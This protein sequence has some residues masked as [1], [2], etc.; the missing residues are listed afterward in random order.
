MI[1][2]NSTFSV[3]HIA[4]TNFNRI[5]QKSYENESIIF[6]PVLSTISVSVE[7]RQ[8]RLVFVVTKWFRRRA[9]H[10][11]P[12]LSQLWACACIECERKLLPNG[13]K[14]FAFAIDKNCYYVL[15]LSLVLFRFRGHSH[16]FDHRRLMFCSYFNGSLLSIVVFMSPSHRFCRSTIDTWVFFVDIFFI[17]FAIEFSYNVH[18]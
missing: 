12:N 3:C 4:R 5:A 15:R 17:D 11:E 7:S 10:N 13:T 8:R 18:F 6:T 9:Q 2:M 16:V 14:L 1:H